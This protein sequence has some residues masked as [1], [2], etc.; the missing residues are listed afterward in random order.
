[1]RLVKSSSQSGNA[2]R[3]GAYA[4]CKPTVDGVEDA[5][6]STTN[7]NYLG[8]SQSYVK[9]LWDEQGLFIFGSERN[10]KSAMEFAVL[11]DSA[12]DTQSKD[13][14]NNGWVQP[15]HWNW[16]DSLQFSVSSD[17][18]M[19]KQ[20]YSAALPAGAVCKTKKTDDGFDLEIY[21]PNPAGWNLTENGTVRFAAYHN[22]SDDLDATGLAY[23]NVGSTFH[24]NTKFVKSITFV[25]NPGLPQIKNTSIALHGAQSSAVA[26]GKFDVRF[27]AEIIGLDAQCAGFE[28]SGSYGSGE[29]MTAIPMQE[30]KTTKAYTSVLAGGKKVTPTK[31]GNYLVA[32]GV[33]D[34]PVSDEIVTVT[35]TVKPFT[36]NA[37]GE[38]L[39]GDTAV[40][41]FVSG[42]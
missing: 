26:D 15:N 31:D 30:L 17:G 13:S 4:A 40:F 8:V 1:M 5:I 14:W 28:I 24:N 11:A 16:Q 41:T 42:Q 22:R 39:Y 2:H 12:D 7:A 34:I 33:F 21:I 6:W 29:N 25:A 19:T 37:E 27:V 38:K 18:T 36:V 23:D 20:S 3:T 9:V 35:F 10:G 32:L